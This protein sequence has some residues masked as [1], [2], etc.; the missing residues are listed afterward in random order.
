M[1]KFLSAFND[2]LSIN[3]TQKFKQKISI[4]INANHIVIALAL[5]VGFLIRFFSLIKYTTFD[6]GPAPDQVRDAFV[7]MDMWRGKMPILGPSASV[8]GYSLPPLYYY[9]VFPFT[10]FGAAPVWQ[11][12]PNA[13]FS[14][15][16]IPAL[17][18]L[19]Y[20]LLEDV[21]QSK[22]LILSGLAGLWYAVIFGEIF[23]STFQWNP[24]PIPFF[25]I[26]CTLIFKYQIETKFSRLIPNLILWLSYGFLMAILVSLHSTAL[27][28]MPVVFLSSLGFYIYQKRRQPYK[29]WLSLLSI[30]AMSVALIPYWKG[31]LARNF[32]N[33]KQIVLV[34]LG[35]GSET[36]NSNLLTKLG[37]IVFNYFELGQQLYFPN[38]GILYLVVSIFFLLLVLCCAIYHFKGNIHI[39]LFLVF[40]WLIYLYAAANFQGIFFIHYKL[41][42]IVAPIVLTVLA[43]AYLDSST[44][45]GL[46][47]TRIIILGIVVSMG[48]NISWDYRYLASKYSRERLIATSDI[49]SVFQ[50]LSPAS[51]I[52]EP[53]YQ[54]NR[55]QINPYNYIDLYITKKNF[56]FVNSCNS[57]NYLIKSKYRMVQ[58]IDNMWPLFT[59]KTNSIDDK[60]MRLISKNNALYLYQQQ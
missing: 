45:I 25:L 18:L 49:I 32:I 58:S 40:T 8:G 24:S 23:I 50:E 56:N 21:K 20:E 22:R 9:L 27:F 44:I 29:C 38:R 59:I 46:I 41:L 47:A 2:S 10:I 1:S 3:N 52:C 55:S 51:T 57:K 33:S 35:T 11:A 14:W 60:S 12:L 30:V 7:Y 15:L 37:K 36:D 39:K 42:F 43:I 13:L 16:A 5:L 28:V 4:N 53:K 26:S 6:I 48:L 17:M 34:V 54:G 19:I 31:E